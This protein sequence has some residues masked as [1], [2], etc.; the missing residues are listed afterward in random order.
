[1]TRPSGNAARVLP[2]TLTTRKCLPSG[3]GA[4]PTWFGVDGDVP[5]RG[6]VVGARAAMDAA[7]RM[8]GVDDLV[9]G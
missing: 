9:E 8:D 2:S 3:M 4:R 6:I 5:R 7:D 1:M